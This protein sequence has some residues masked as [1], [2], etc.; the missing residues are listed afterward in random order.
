MR[1]GLSLLS[2]NRTLA[3]VEITNGGYLK[4]DTNDEVIVVKTI[5][6][7]IGFIFGWLMISFDNGEVVKMSD[8]V[9]QAKILNLKN[10]EE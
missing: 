5:D 1:L 7:N 3:G 6:I 10:K 4:K 8:I 9:K 2:K